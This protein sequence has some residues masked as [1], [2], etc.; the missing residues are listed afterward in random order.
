MTNLR[1]HGTSSPP[2]WQKWSFD[3]KWGEICALA[4]LAR[5]LVATHRPGQSHG[6]A[7]AGGWG[8]TFLTLLCSLYSP[9]VL[10]L[11][12]MSVTQPAPAR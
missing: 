4:T 8:R 1:A 3:G 9:N 6:S 10:T 2:G 12:A 7:E 11:Y 5:L